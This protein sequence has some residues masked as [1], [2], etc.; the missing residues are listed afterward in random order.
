M[1]KVLIGLLVV[2]VIIGVAATVFVGKLDQLIADAIETEGSAALGSQVKVESVVT[3]LK[4]GIATINGLSV[5][6]PS[7]YKAV[8]ALQIGSF[9]ADVDYQNQIVE[10]ILINKPVINAELKGTM[11]N[12]E[13]LLANMPESDDTTESDSGEDMVI[14]IN[15]FQLR[16]AQINLVAKQ[17]GERSFVMDDFVINNLK[18]TPEQIS[19][20]LTRGLTDHVSSQI[21]SYAT[22]EITKILTEEARK[23]VEEV[24]NEKIKEQVGDKLNVKLGDELGDKLGDKLKSFKFG[25]D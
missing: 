4:E 7:G 15:S 2:A 9:S 17:L 23:K 18:G 14:T 3:Q 24:I 10:K 25:K 22:S 13:E 19:A 12:F 20:V 1:K 6:N 8:S 11:N 5:A 16:Q 21:K